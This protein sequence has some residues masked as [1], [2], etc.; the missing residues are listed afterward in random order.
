MA[1][2]SSFIELRT[3]SN[4][5]WLPPKPLWDSDTSEDDVTVNTIPV[6]AMVSNQITIKTLVDLPVFSWHPV[7]TKYTGKDGTC[8]ELSRVQDWLFE[9]NKIGKAGG[10]TPRDHGYSSGYE[11]RPRISSG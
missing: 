1:K 8:T 11:A 9:I 10:W 4:F 7:N 3:F 5:V 2:K 6:S